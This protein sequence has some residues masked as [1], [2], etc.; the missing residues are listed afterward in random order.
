M[1]GWW[2]KLT[3]CFR[4]VA[5]ITCASHAQGPRFDPGRKQNLFLYSLFLNHNCNAVPYSTFFFAI[6]YICFFLTSG[7]GHCFVRGEVLT[8]NINTVLQR[9]HGYDAVY[10]GRYVPVLRRN[11][12]SNHPENGGR[13]FLRNRGTFPPNYTGFTYLLNRIFLQPVPAYKGFHDFFTVPP[14]EC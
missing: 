1:K 10:F 7:H 8:L 6:I 5:V 14:D 9:L 11:F 2:E 13:N 3:C 4:S 12:M